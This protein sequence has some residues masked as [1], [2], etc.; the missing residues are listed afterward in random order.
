MNTFNNKKWFVTSKFKDTVTSKEFKSKGKYLK[1]S[2]FAIIV[3]FVVAGVLIGIL[4]VN[5]FDYFFKMFQVAFD[6]LYLTQTFNWIAV[7]IVGGVAMAIGFKSGVFNIGASGQILTATSMSTIVLFSIVPKNTTE[8]NGQTIFL[9]FLVSVFSGAFMAFIAG[10]LKALFNMHEVVTTI[11]LNWVAW[12]F[13]KWIFTY[14]YPDEFGGGLAGSS[15]HI[16]DGLL[17]IGGN[18]IIAPLLIAMGVVV[19]AAIVLAKT[20]F[21]FKLKAVGSAPEAAKYSGINVKQK[22]VLAMTIS[23]GIAGIAGFIS[24][25][26]LNPNTYFGNDNLPTLGFDVIAIS[27]VAFNNP[28]GLIF[29]GALWGV[30]QNAG[31]PISSLYG[32]PTQIAGL[33]SGIIIYLAAIS[34]VFI[35]FNPVQIFKMWIFVLKS[36][37]DRKMLLILYKKKWAL[38]LKKPLIIFNKD[39]QKAVKAAETKADQK[40]VKLDLKAIDSLA[41]THIKTS[42]KELKKWIWEKNTIKGLKGIKR[43]NDEAIQTINA[44]TINKIE[45]AKL[46]FGIFKDEVKTR[47]I[48]N[49]ID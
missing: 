37:N 17:S 14:G 6:E 30:I 26:T 2:I 16:P 46:K 41:L 27:L 5:P 20:T 8:I 13:F 19:I 23:G 1:G 36:K 44:E 45:A 33:V 24:M 38:L 22:I 39:Y 35:M 3:G 42:I 40:I 28:V 4:N 43:R 11:L 21:G 15:Q 12:Y 48:N 29:V 10:M 34:A 9:L 18:E 31:A 7:Y 25:C 47:K 32:I 49:Y